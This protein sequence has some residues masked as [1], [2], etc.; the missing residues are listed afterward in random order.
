MGSHLDIKTALQDMHAAFA[1]T[2]LECANI[3]FSLPCIEHE[4]FKVVET[5]NPAFDFLLSLAGNSNEYKAISFVGA[6]KN[7]LSALLNKSNVTLEDARDILGEYSNSYWGMLQD[8]NDFVMNFGHIEQGLPSL[9]SGGNVFLPFIWGIEGSINVQ[10]TILYVAFS[11]RANEPVQKWEGFYPLKAE[12]R[13][14]LIWITFPSF[15]N[16]KYFSEIKNEKILDMMSNPRGIVLDLSKVTIMLSAYIGLVAHVGKLSLQKKI[17][18][19][20]VVS[21]PNCRK[22]LESTNIPKIAMIYDSEKEAL[23]AL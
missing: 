15:L 13:K 19:S 16:V 17:P 1:N 20:I 2:A 22:V 18:I 10:N 14:D 4:P 11:I 23:T 6:Q 21:S 5:M 12:T 3:F 7:L 8:H 9:Y